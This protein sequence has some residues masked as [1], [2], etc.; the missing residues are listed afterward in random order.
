MPGGPDPST[1]LA[2]D[3]RHP[4]L[5]AS[6]QHRSTRDDSGPERVAARRGDP[7]AGRVGTRAA[8]APRFGVNDRRCNDGRD[9]PPSGERQP[10]T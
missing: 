1:I 2:I 4:Q 8:G 5:P 3:T 6:S 9:E 7:L 10:L